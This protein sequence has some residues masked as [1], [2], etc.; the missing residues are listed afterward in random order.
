MVSP[1]KPE[2]LIAEKKHPENLHEDISTLIESTKSQM[3]HQVNSS[4]VMLYW[5]IGHR[6]HL[7]VLKEERAEYGEQVIKELG[8]TLML[9]YGRGFG[10][11]NL[12]KMVQFSKYYPDE[13]IVPTLSAQL[14][15][16]HFIELI[17]IDDPL[18]CQFY[19]ELCRLELW[20]VREL[21]KKIDGMLYER[22]AISHRPDK[23]IKNDLDTLKQKSEISQDLVFRDP[24]ILDFLSLPTSYSENDL[25]DAILND[26]CLFLQELGNDFCF[27]GRQKRI[28]IDHED[29]YI[30]LLMYHRGLRRIICIDLKLGRFEAGHK[31][32]ME[33]YLRWL[34]KYERKNGEEAPLG[35]ILCAEKKHGHIELLELDK[36]G[37]HVAQYLTQLPPKEILEMRLNKAI[38]IA[39]ER[40]ARIEKP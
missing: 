21:R 2:K 35:L 6:I 7:E 33:L 36:S 28:T 38:E 1:K 17:V 39:K 26:L 4:M 30:D 18:K 23:V 22:T 25:E 5:K 10:A 27:I 9:K 31:G 32:Q 3:F 24:Y 13:N 14:S 34:N 15:W 8:K 29:Y 20:S 16:S 12:F 37:I 40:Q 19:T 11:R